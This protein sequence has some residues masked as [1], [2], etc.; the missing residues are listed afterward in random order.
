MS[1]SENR[2]VRLV[3]RALSR[4]VDAKHKLEVRRMRG[5]EGLESYC[6]WYGGTVLAGSPGLVR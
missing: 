6:C 5:G 4:H 3:W 1:K 2:V